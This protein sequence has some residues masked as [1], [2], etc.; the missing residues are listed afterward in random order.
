M[1]CFLIDAVILS[2]V[3]SHHKQFFYFRAA[4]HLHRADQE[5]D[6]QLLEARVCSLRAGDPEALRVRGQIVHGAFSS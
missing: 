1:S 3:Y 4:H 2:K 5:P 6:V